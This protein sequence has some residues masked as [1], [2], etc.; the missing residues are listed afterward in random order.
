MSKTTL[1]V[2]TVSMVLFLLILIAALVI[3]VVKLSSV[4]AKKEQLIDNLA[5]IEQEIKQNQDTIDYLS[6]DEYVDQYAREYLN[7][8]GKNEEAFTGK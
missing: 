8:Q 2:I 5:R 6:T 3:N 1:R 4:N 7:M